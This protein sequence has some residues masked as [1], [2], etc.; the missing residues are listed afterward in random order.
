MITR[1]LPGKVPG[2]CAATKGS[3]YIIQHIHHPPE[4]VVSVIQPLE[5]TSREKSFPSKRILG[6]CDRD[7]KARQRNRTHHEGRRRALTSSVFS[8]R[9]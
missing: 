3:L 9:L 8:S 4:D 7:R 2:V 5:R 1:R 6:N